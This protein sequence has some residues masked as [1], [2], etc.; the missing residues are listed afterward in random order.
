MSTNR[1][2]IEQRISEQNALQQ[3]L[4]FRKIE[5][6]AS[7]EDALKKNHRGNSCYVFRVSVQAKGSRYENL[8]DQDTEA[9]YALLI[10][11]KNVRSDGNSD[12]SDKAETLAESVR[13][14]IL[15]Y[16]P[17]SESGQLIWRGGHL[18]QVKNGYYAWQEIYSL[19]GSIRQV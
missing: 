16:Q 2:L 18:A 10:I 1:Q 15:G 13:Q 8:V 7:L 11:V 9:F 3:P 19:S 6:A 5:G 12:S 17:S 14:W 4:L